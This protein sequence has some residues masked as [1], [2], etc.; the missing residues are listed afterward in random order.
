[1]NAFMLMTASGPFVILTS[2]SSVLDAT[3]ITRLREKGIEKFVAFEIPI[4]LAEQ[5]YGT[6][7]TIVK[8]DIRQTDD[9]R[10]LDEDGEHAF[11][12]FCFGEL[13]PPIVHEPRVQW[14]PET[15]YVA[16][17]FSHE[18]AN[19]E[20]KFFETPEELESEIQA[21]KKTGRYVRICSAYGKSENPNEWQQIENWLRD[22]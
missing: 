3:L 13:G 1:M 2:H 11:K 12:H 17:L 4:A 8:G 19:P 6:H 21:H 16:R 5:R 14:M 9:L 20:T 22:E 18:N 7:F 10:V 15:P